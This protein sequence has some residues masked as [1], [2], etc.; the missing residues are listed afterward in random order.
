MFAYRYIWSI[1]RSYFTN[2]LL[3]RTSIALSGSLCPLVIKI[4]WYIFWLKHELFFSFIW[5]TWR[6]DSFKTCFGW[7]QHTHVNIQKYYCSWNKSLCQVVKWPLLVHLSQRILSCEL[8]WSPFVCG[9]LMFCSF[10]RIICERFRP[11]MASS[12][13]VFLCFN[14]LQAVIKG[15]VY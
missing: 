12:F 11:I 9:S 1:P 4:L 5:R 2:S 6:F 10:C 14:I 7:K 8:F 13:I 3:T 15:S